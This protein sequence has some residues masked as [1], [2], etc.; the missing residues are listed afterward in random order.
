MT[1][2][3]PAFPCQKGE[4]LQVPHKEPFTAIG[5]R[6]G[7]RLEDTIQIPRTDDM[8]QRQKPFPALGQ[9]L[10]IRSALLPADL[11]K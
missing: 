5:E 10:E 7:A 2:P 11:L 4:T 3:G 1:D 9:I 6:L 8:G